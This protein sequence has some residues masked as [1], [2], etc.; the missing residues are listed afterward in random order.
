VIVQFTVGGFWPGLVGLMGVGELDLGA[1][2]LAVGATDQ[3]HGVVSR[4]VG[5]GGSA[6][7]VD[8]EAGLEPGQ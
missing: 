8:Q 7:L 4:L 1:V 6:V 2:L 5:N 3:Q